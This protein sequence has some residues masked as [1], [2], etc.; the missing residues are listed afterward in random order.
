MVH[1]QKA[2]GLIGKAT[3]VHEHHA[4]LHDYNDEMQRQKDVNKQRQ[5]FLFPSKLRYGF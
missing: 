1:V 4:F 2:I 5:N 3:T